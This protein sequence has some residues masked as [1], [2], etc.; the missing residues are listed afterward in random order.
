VIINPTVSSV[1]TATGVSSQG[2]INTKTVAVSINTNTLTITQNT[3]ICSGSTMTLNASG[4]TN[5]SWSSGGSFNSI[6]VSP[7]VNTVYTATGE[8]VLGCVLSNTVSVNINALPVVSISA[9][10]QF[11]CQ[12]ETVTLTANGAN[13]YVW[14]NADTNPAVTKTLS[15]NVPYHYSVTGT[16]A[17]GCTSSGM[18]TVV[19][20]ACTGV[21][22]NVGVSVN[23]FPNP[24]KHEVF[25]Y[26]ESSEQKI[27]TVSD[28]TGKILLIKETSDKQFKFAVGELPA[29]I[30]NLQIT[31]H[32]QSTH[33]KLIKQ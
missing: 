22:E 27:V 15:V 13:S 7:T 14:D 17:N 33:H 19:A 29:A 6:I 18:I 20:N 26:T 28:M 5:V 10:R 3:T 25:I 8:D 11:I 30:Y 23:I 24:A 1:Y 2:C 31:E 16:N 4:V 12:G 32:D 21:T 9:N